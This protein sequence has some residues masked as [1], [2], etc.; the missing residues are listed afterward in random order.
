MYSS[1]ILPAMDA[2][3]NE[4]IL[5]PISARGAIELKHVYVQ[6][7]IHS[8]LQEQYP[9]LQNLQN[10]FETFTYIEK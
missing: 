10:L 6:V 3:I 2:V 4:T 1:L 8:M 7:R 5:P 9:L